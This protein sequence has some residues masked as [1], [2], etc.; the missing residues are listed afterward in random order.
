MMWRWVLIAVAAVGPSGC[1]VFGYTLVRPGAAVDVAGSGLIVSPDRAWNRAGSINGPGKDAERWTLDGPALNEL[2]LYAG[3]RDGRPLFREE[4]RRDRPLPRFSATML[5][6]DVAA[7]FEASYRVASG[8]SL[9]TID[10]IAPDSLAGRPGFRFDYSYVLPGEEV[11][12]KGAATGAI[13]GG[14]LYLI[15]FEAPAIHYFDRDVG[16][17]RAIVAAAR[18]KDDARDVGDI[19]GPLT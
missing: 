10:A 3:I 1:A 19:P 11:R 7:L 8:T 5:P 14:K 18:L 15:S 16:A 6:V 4:D 9:F 13:V 12:R 2:T 17:Y